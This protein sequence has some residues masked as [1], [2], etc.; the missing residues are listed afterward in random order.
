MKCSSDFDMA[1]NIAHINYKENI[2][3]ASVFC[4]H[5]D[6]LFRSPFWDTLSP[7][8]IELAAISRQDDENVSALNCL[9]GA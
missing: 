5:F 4:H 1:L 8:H 6:V 7:R 3:E 9:S 2:L